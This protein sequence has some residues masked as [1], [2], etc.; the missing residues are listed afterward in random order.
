MP[1][2]CDLY[3]HSPVSKSADENASVNAELGAK[4]HG[5]LGEGFSLPCP[6]GA[7][8]DQRGLVALGLGRYILYDL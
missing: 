7:V 1:R 5:G 6:K 2:Q 3:N 8:D 4:Q